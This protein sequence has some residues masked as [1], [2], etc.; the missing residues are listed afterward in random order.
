M[1]VG[2]CHFMALPW[3]IFALWASPQASSGRG[4]LAPVETS[5]SV[6]LVLRSCPSNLLNLHQFVGFPIVWYPISIGH[7][8]KPACK[9][10]WWPTALHPLQVK[11]KVWCAQPSLCWIICCL[12]AHSW[13]ASIAGVWECFCMF[14]QFKFQR[15]LPLSNLHFFRRFGVPKRNRTWKK[16]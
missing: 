15:A 9:L 10:S 6:T 2:G 4:G 3:E 5:N 14:S 1:F 11:S 7:S 13:F 12:L 8:H 16:C